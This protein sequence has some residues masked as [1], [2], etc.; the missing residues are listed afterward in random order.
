VINMVNMRL[1]N[2]TKSFEDV[3]AVDHVSIEAAAGEFFTL[4]GPSGCG[5]TTTLR[6]VAGFYDPDEGEIYFGNKLMNNVP[7]NER[8]T[9]MVFQSYAIF[10]HMNVFQNV[11]Y[12]LKI[13]KMNNE[14]VKREVEWVLKLVKMEGMEERYPTQLSGGQQQRVALAR[15]LVIKPDVLLLDEPLSNL[16]AKLRVEMRTEIRRIQREMKTTTIYVTHD[17]EEALC[18]S[19]KISVMNRGRVEQTGS[20]REIYETPRNLFV[21]D[22]VGVTNFFR[23]KLSSISKDGKIATLETDQGFPIEVQYDGEG[24]VG[25]EVSVALRPEAADITSCHAVPKGMNTTHGRV[26]LASYLGDVVRYEVETDY[27]EVMRVDVHNPTGRQVFSEGTPVSL[28]F[29]PESVKIIRE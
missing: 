2:L 29:P 15:A 5:K 12:G 7:P 27:G 6:M 22:F 9:G 13:R 3:V 24:M 16:D 28:I 19:D 10:P 8:N 4:L 17:Q 25:S 26:K 23:G 20:P 1:V 21:A 11:S 18:V 14:D